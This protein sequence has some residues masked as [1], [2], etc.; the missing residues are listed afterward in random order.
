MKILCEV[1]GGGEVRLT[2]WW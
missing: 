2:T 1:H